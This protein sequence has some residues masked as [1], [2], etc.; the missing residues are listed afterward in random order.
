MPQGAL[1]PLIPERAWLQETIIV[2]YNM[3]VQGVAW[4]YDMA[5]QMW[6]DGSWIAK[7][8][9]ARLDVHAYT[10]E[11]MTQLNFHLIKQ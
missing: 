7:E 3:F 8:A 11:K 9:K 5:A 4:A 10:V 1:R 6:H 2:H